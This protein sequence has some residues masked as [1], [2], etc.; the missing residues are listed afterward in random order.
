MH[1]DVTDTVATHWRAG[2]QRV[3]LQVLA[4]LRA[5]QRLEVRPVV[6]LES[7]RSFRSLTPH[8]QASLD[9]FGS[10]RS[11]TP[12]P[13]GKPGRPARVLAAVRP[14]LGHV[15]RA[16]KALLVATRIEPLL[17]RA[18]SAVMR[19]S[20]DRHLVPL[21]V[22]LPSG[23]VLLEMDTVWNNLWLDRSELYE[24]L[25]AGGV[26]VAALV[27]DLLPQEHPEWFENSLVKVSD[28][29]IRAQVAG[30]D[31]L[32]VTS[33]DGAQ[34]VVSW[35]SDQGLDPV[36]PTVVTLGADGVAAAPGQDPSDGTGSPAGSPAE[37][38]A[39]L[40]GA[41]FALCVGTI[42][43]RTNHV[44]LRDAFDL[45]WADDPGAHLV[46]VGRPGWHSEDVIA[47][48]VEHPHVGGRLHW[49]RG[50]DDAQLEA[51]Y[52]SARVVAVASLAEGYGLPVI[53]ALSHSTPVVASDVG[54]LVE[55]GAGLVDHVGARDAS[56][57]A[58]AMGSLLAD[59]SAAVLRRK[60]LA[61]YRPPVWADT[62]RQVAGLLVERFVASPA[63]YDPG[64]KP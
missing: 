21:V 28:R 63:Q 15:R 30:A 9:P 57:W 39:E 47:R 11:A 60:A 13:V 59:D 16:V 34:R 36:E 1:V 3:V 52:E 23:S 18:R 43:P 35:A 41:R 49:Y 62:G 64:S 42:E 25:H 31:L 45:I 29:T 55:A 44:T 32:L 37:L 61:D 2:I 8:E 27:H 33:N 51:F 50:V 6:W 4:Q 20:R 10:E 14:R 56:A 24:Q 12:D 46:L 26:L 19:V 7:A 40:E 48:I 5:D 17:R 58:A 22:D 38:P 53:E 54:A